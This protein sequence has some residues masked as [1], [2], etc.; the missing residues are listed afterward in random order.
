MAGNKLTEQQMLNLVRGPPAEDN[1]VISVK[2]EGH[3]IQ[4]TVVSRAHWQAL[5]TPIKGLD[6]HGR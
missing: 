1:V 6:K 2:V 3:P 4:Y 5:N